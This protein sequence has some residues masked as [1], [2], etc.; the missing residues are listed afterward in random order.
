MSLAIA[1]ANCGGEDS[2]ADVMSNVTQLRIFSSSEP[3][4]IPDSGNSTLW[5]DNVRAIWDPGYGGD[6]F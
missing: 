1:G 5:I 3:G 6:A 4:W 2:L